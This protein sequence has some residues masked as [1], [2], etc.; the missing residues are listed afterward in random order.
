MKRAELFQHLSVFVRVTACVAGLLGCHHAEVAKPAARSETPPIVIDDAFRERAL[1][2]DMDLL[3]DPSRALTFAD[4][5]APEHA[6]RFVPSTKAAPNF[7]YTPSA[8]WA[9]FS[10]RDERNAA[11]HESGDALELTLAYAQTDFAELWCVAAPGLDA[12]PV[13]HARAGDHVPLA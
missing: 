10:L 2:L 12:L 13:V 3:E 9:R 5:R 8:Y 4:V 11:K 7:G 6:A 1:G